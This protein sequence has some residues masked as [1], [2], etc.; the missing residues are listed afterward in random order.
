MDMPI[1]RGIRN[2]IDILHQVRSSVFQIGHAAQLIDGAVEMIQVDAGIRCLERSGHG[3]FIELG[4]PLKKCPA[5]PDGRY[6]GNRMVDVDHPKRIISEVRRV[7]SEFRPVRLARVNERL[8]AESSFY[9][10]QVSVGEID[11]KTRSLRS[12]MIGI[13]VFHVNARSEV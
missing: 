4:V 9:R 11:P 1:K 5:W 3:R 2:V 8:P 6:S 12:S 13:A 7:V 10:V